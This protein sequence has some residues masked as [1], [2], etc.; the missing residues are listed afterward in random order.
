MPNWCYNRLIVKSNDD[1]S[2]FRRF[3]DE[4]RKKEMIEGEQKMVWRISNYFPTPEKLLQENLSEIDKQE[5]KTMYGFDDWYEWR[6]FNWG[7]KWDCDDYGFESST[8]EK[9]YYILDF[10]SAWSPP[11]EFLINVSIIYPTLSFQLE[12]I[13]PGNQFAGTTYINNGIFLDLCGEPVQ[14]NENG[15]IIDVTYDEENEQYVLSNG[16]VF[17]EDDWYDQ[18]ISI[19]KNPFEDFYY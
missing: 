1:K 6:L 2:S 19:K 16:E 8:D 13:E 12:Y 10:D 3:M 5:L 15:E 17:N 4:G 18:D 14:K 11:I 9:S 7:T